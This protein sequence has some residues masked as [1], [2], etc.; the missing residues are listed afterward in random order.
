MGIMLHKLFS[1]ANDIKKPFVMS[2]ITAA[3]SLD[4]RQISKFISCENFQQSLH[5]LQNPSAYRN[6]KVGNEYIYHVNMMYSNFNILS[7]F[8]FNS[9]IFNTISSN[10]TSLLLLLGARITIIIK[11]NSDINDRGRNNAAY[12][13]WLHLS[14]VICI[15]LTFTQIAKRSENNNEMFKLAKNIFSLRKEGMDIYRQ[16]GKS[17]EEFQLDESVRP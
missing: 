14:M 2:I 15:G 10:I 6:N 8:L 12:N 4:Y 17:P 16:F 7:N 5:F 3:N 11:H 1:V 13:F 9:T